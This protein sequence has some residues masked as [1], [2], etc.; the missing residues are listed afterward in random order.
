MRIIKEH[1]AK[2]SLKKRRFK[3]SLSNYNLRDLRDMLLNAKFLPNFDAVAQF[4][5]SFYFVIS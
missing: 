4:R 5:Y 3:A 1:I 2:S